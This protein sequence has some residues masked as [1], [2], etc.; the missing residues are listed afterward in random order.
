VERTY[1]LAW[2][3][4]WP[5]GA[6]RF[7]NLVEQLGSA[8]VAWDAGED[9]L[10]A[11]GLDRKLARELVSKKKRFDPVAAEEKVREIGARVI[12]WLDQ[13]YPARL[14]HIY[15]PPAVLFVLGEGSFSEATAAVAVVGSRKATPYGRSVARK[16]AADL[17][18]CGL[19]VV[20]GMARGIDTAA[21]LGALDAGATT[22]AVL[23]SGVDVVYPRENEQ[24]MA[25]IAATGLVV[26]EFPP[27]SEPLAWRFPLRNRII[28]GLSSAVVVVEAGE[29]SGALITAALALEQGRDVLAVPGS[30]NNPN[31]RGPHR[32]IKEGARLVENAGDVLDELGLDTLFP[33]IGTGSGGAGVEQLGPEERLVLDSLQ[34]EGLSDQALIAITGLPAARVGAVLAYLE[35]KGFV[36]RAPGGLYYSLHRGE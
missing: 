25:K 23:G 33:G 6:R 17:G 28:S 18:T 29:R 16:L 22:V 11:A 13:D 19:V 36:R 4:I 8:K 10:V 24:L 1:W 35:I 21:H 2:A 9:A 30:I 14:R 34:G 5:A 26:S 20:S 7:L 3:S 12:T 31:S 27:G 32:L 15:D